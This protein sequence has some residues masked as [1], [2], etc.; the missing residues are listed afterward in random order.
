[1]HIYLYDNYV[2]ASR[3]AA[4]TARIETR[5]TDLGL[6]GKIV[7][8]SALNSVP[9]AVAD[10]IRKGAKTFVAVGNNNLFNRLINAV[11]HLSAQDAYQYTVPI[12]LIPVGRDQNDIAAYLGIEPEERACDILAARRIETLDLGL[13]NNQ[14]F[15]AHASIP[16]LGTSV[17][18]D[19]DYS[20]EIL[21]K[22]TVSIVNLPINIALPETVRANAKDGVL[23]LMIRTDERSGIGTRKTAGTESVFSFTRLTLTNKTRP[24]TLD[25]AIEIPG[26]VTVTIAKEK[27]N[28]IVGKNRRF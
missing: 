6:N 1:M 7:R 15:F 4:V 18:I 27:I 10:E 20:I 19:T 12:A 24:V 9:N 22:G 3:Y 14:Y 11:A 23:E 28:C 21:K 16:T 25:N 2:A 13:A 5:I 17:E 26:P 8:L